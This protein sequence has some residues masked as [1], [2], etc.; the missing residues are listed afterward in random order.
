M[1]IL[2]VVK[3]DKLRSNQDDKFLDINLGSNMREI[4]IIYNYY[5]LGYLH[6]TI[7]D[8]RKQRSYHFNNQ[9]E[10]ELI[11]DWQEKY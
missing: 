10:L 7:S 11:Q 8:T 1:P 4:E 9:G 3:S 5:P 6:L 2:K